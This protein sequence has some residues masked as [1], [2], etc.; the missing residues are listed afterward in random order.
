MRKIKGAKAE[1]ALAEAAGTG[2]LAMEVRIAARTGRVLAIDVAADGRH[3][4]GRRRQRPFPFPARPRRRG[5]LA[6]RP[7]GARACRAQD[8]RERMLD[9]GPRDDPAVG[10][11]LAER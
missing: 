6:Q 4:G 10:R 8:R 3:D 9:R 11:D 7:S 2:D 5:P 1:V